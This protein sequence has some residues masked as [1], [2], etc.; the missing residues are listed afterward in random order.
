MTEFKKK[1]TIV[2]V[3][4]HSVSLVLMIDTNF[5][6]PDELNAAIKMACKN[7][8]A[9]QAGKIRYEQNGYTFDW[10]DVLSLPDVICK[11]YGFTI[12]SVFVTENCHDMH[13]RICM[14]KTT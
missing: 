14:P 3:D 4:E 2:A 12:A 13:E 6:E 1:Q 7:Y 10:S 5:N 8:L 9:T 11:M